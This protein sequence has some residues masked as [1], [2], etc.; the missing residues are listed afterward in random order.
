MLAASRADPILGPLVDALPIP[1]GRRGAPAEIATVV[2]FLL[3]PD[4]GYVHGSVLFADGGS[5]ALLRPD[6]V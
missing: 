6:A 1:L 2:A 3:G 4:S 5:D